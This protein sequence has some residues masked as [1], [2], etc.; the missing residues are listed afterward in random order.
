M[1]EQEWITIVAV[2]VSIAVATL[3]WPSVLNWSRRRAFMSL[4][5]R[6]L[7][8]IEPYPETPTKSEWSEH[9]Q[10]NFVHQRIFADVSSNRDFLLSLDPNITYYVSQLWDAH[11]NRNFDQWRYYLKKLVAFDSTGKTA[12]ILAKWEKLQA[13]YKSCAI[14][15]AAK[16]A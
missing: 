6:E 3:F 13:E 12:L 4:I 11:A 9:L 14:E 15:N 10:K 2:P 8:E 1:T 5:S 16:E 7:R